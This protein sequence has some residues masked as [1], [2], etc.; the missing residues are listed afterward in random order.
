V[1][2]WQLDISA[3][4]IRGLERLHLVRDVRWPKPERV[5]AKLKDPALASRVRGYRPVAA[6]VA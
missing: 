5:V 1:L 2:K 4:M 3:L 6:P